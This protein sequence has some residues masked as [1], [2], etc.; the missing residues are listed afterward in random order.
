MDPA[1]TSFENGCPSSGMSGGVGGGG[2]SGESTG[3]RG[4][5]RILLFDSAAFVIWI[6]K[7]VRSNVTMKKLEL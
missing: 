2:G 5:C 3:N 1:G 7:D 6:L 4:W